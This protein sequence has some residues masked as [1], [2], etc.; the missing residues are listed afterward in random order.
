M[1]DFL[2]FKIIFSKYLS[3]FRNRNVFHRQAL[4]IL[5]M[6]HAIAANELKKLEKRKVFRTNPIPNDCH[7]EGESPKVRRSSGGAIIRF[8]TPAKVWMDN[9][10]KNSHLNYHS[11][12]HAFHCVVSGCEFSNSPPVHRNRK[13]TKHTHNKHPEQCT[14]D[15]LPVW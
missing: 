7:Y 3:H 9:D 1:Y 8:S 11:E 13:M 15:D 2:T 6:Q 10:D 5:N 14:Y 12:E 4:T